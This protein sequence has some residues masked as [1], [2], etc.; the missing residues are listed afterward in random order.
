[1]SSLVS[2]SHTKLLII[3]TMAILLGGAIQ[4]A[5]QSQR[6]TNVIVFLADDLGYQE[7]GC[8]GQKI[9]KTPSIDALAAGGMRMTHF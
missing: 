2:S 3:A 4:G 9:I 7:L 6:P 8:Y 1:M 5:D